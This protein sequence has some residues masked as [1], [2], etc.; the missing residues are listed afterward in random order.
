MTIKSGIEQALELFDGSASKMAAAV[1]AGVIRQHI[2][3]WSKAGK[4]PADRA[5][6]VEA[7][8]GIPVEVLAPDAPWVRVKDRKWPHPSGRPLVDFAANAKADEAAAA[9]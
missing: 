1:G 5:P 3:H 8:T 2:E 9:A 7:A 4:V 6:A